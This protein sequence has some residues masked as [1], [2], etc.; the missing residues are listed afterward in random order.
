MGIYALNVGVAT[1]INQSLSKVKTYLDNNTLLLGDSNTALSAIDRSSRHSNSKETRALKDTVDQVDLTD[2]Y[3]TLHPN[4]TEFT[5]FSIARGTLSRRDHILGHKSGHN[6]YQNFG[7][8]P[9]IFSAHNALK[10][11]LNHK[12]FARISNTCRLRTILLKGE[13]VNQDIREELRKFTETNENE[14]TTNRSESLGY[15]KSGP[16]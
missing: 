2:I 7:I 15:S 5:F 11:E 13:R 16:K 1:D 10:L 14:D 12:K 6:R 4:A 8:V 3:R 9:C